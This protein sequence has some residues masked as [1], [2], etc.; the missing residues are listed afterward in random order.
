MI[1]NMQHNNIALNDSRNPAVDASPLTS[2][3]RAG[4]AHPLK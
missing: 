1:V 2:A 3:H 4:V